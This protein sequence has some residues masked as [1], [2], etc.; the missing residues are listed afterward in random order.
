MS[1]AHYDKETGDMR[2]TSTASTKH[3]RDIVN[4]AE[5]RH[6]PIHR[7]TC[8]ATIKSNDEVPFIA[9]TFPSNA[10]INLPG[11]SHQSQ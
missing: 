1:S 4:E 8:A 9:T 6:V 5:K 10:K 7:V 3:A 2:R 11:V